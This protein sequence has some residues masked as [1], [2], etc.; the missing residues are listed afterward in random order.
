LRE[1]GRAVWLQR[2]MR[3]AREAAGSASRHDVSWRGPDGVGACWRSC[4]R[5]GCAG[6]DGDAA[7][8]RIERSWACSG[9]VARAPHPQHTVLPPVRHSP[10]AAYAV[11][12][13]DDNSRSSKLPRFSTCESVWPEMITPFFT[14]CRLPITSRMRA[15]RGVV[16]IPAGEHWL[17]VAVEIWMRSPWG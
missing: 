9:S 5:P 10:A 7:V 17:T 1:N 14:V 12:P 11:G 13:V 6:R 15:R 2:S 16:G 8:A 4:V 3:G